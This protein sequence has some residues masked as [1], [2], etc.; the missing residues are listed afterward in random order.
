MLRM[1]DYVYL[2]RT[3]GRREVISIYSEYLNRMIYVVINFI[4]TD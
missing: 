1:E 4:F 3:G 2:L